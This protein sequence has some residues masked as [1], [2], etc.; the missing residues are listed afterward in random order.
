MGYAWVK[1]DV[2]GVIPIVSLWILSKSKSAKISIPC[3]NTFIWLTRLLSYFNQRMV[4]ISD[5]KKNMGH[6]GFLSLLYFR[7]LL[8]FRSL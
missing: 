7:R 1:E 6:Q 4:E 8:Y 2:K 5:M 3:S